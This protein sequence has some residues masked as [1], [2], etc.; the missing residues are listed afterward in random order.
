MADIKLLLKNAGRYKLEN[1]PEF[2]ANVKTQ[3]DAAGT[4]DLDCNLAALKLCLLFPNESKIEVIQGILLKAMMVFPKTDFSLCMYQIPQKYHAELK[5]LLD[6]ARSLEMC[7]FK[8][9]WK[10]AESAEILKL[11]S[12]WQDDVRT[13]I[14]GV[15]ATTYRSV[16]KSDLASLLNL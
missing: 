10:E 6:L 8:A 9:F 11:V 4:Y 16:S 2:E 3:L 12:G 7:N 14:A 13:F 5:P 1:L 15:V